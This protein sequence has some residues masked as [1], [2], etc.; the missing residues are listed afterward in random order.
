MFH[1]CINLEPRNIESV[2]MACCMLHNFLIA[3]SSRTYIPPECFDY[4]TEEGR[5]QEIIYI[6]NSRDIR[7][8]VGTVGIGSLKPPCFDRDTLIV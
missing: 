2:V 4:D 5:L 1:T 7:L 8:C 6:I 3:K